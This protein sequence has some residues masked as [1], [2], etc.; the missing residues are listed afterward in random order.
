MNQ[1]TEEYSAEDPPCVGDEVM[2]SLYLDV[3][4]CCSKRGMIGTIVEITGGGPSRLI[5]FTWSACTEKCQRYQGSHQ[6]DEAWLT[7][8][9]AIVRMAPPAQDVWVDD[10][11]LEP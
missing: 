3:Q 9:K 7:K 11:V 8:D 6:W 5:R 1:D 4:D 10:L 2:R